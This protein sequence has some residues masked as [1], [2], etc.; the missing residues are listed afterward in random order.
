VWRDSGLRHVS[1]TQTGHDLRYEV[2]GTKS[3]TGLWAERLQP[4][5]LFI[6]FVVIIIIIIII[7]IIVVLLFYVYLIT[8]RDLLYFVFSYVQFVIHNHQVT[9]P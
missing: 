2:E 1:N 5:L 9:H 7:I 6:T 4:A 3:S 8:Y